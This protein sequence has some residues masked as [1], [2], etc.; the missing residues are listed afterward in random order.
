MGKR[1]SSDQE[2]WLSSPSWGEVRGKL[3][4]GGSCYPVGGAGVLQLRPLDQ[5]PR[6]ISWEQILNAD[7]LRRVWGGGRGE[8][9]PSVSVKPSRGF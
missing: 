8:G 2:G 1:N 3:A 7:S 6:I 9:Q 4:G 5:R